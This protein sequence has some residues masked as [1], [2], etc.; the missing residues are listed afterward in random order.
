MALKIAFLVYEGVAELDFIGPKDVFFASNLL[1]Q[2]DDLLYTV[3]P[4]ND[5]VRC[6]G[7]LKII[8]DYDFTSA[9]RPDILVVPGTGDP[10]PPLEN[11]ELLTW[12][13]EASRNCIW[14][15]GVCTGTAILIA[16]GPAKGRKVTTHWMAIEELRAQ[17]QAT[18]LKGVRYVSDG[19]LVTSAGVSAGIDMALWMVGQIRSPEHARKVQELLEYY[20]QPPYALES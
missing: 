11:I 15:A 9:P 13:D 2:R 18:I 19:Q 5:P 8:P 4:S 20:P 10:T 12:V 6:F 17:S 1:G 16:A 14:T 3:A 7:G